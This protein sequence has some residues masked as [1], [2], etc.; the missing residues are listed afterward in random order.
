MPEDRPYENVFALDG[1]KRHIQSNGCFRGTRDQWEL[2]WGE[3]L[4]PLGEGCR[5]LDAGCGEHRWTASDFEVVSCDCWQTYK[6]R[7]EAEPPEW[8]DDVDLDHPWPYPDDSFYAVACLEVIEHLENPWHFTREAT[9]V[10]TDLVVI[11]TPNPCSP[12]S[13]ALLTQLGRPWGFLPSQLHVNRHLSPVFP[14]QIELMVERVGWMLEPFRYLDGV[15]PPRL[16]P[17][18]LRDLAARRPT[19]KSMVAVLRPEG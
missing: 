12:L 19:S 18:A 15:F 11:S 9:R 10:A 16:V 13:T 3:V 7:E 2:F 5:V 8:V 17:T 4:P 1:P 6:N 14:W